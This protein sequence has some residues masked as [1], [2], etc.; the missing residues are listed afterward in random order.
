MGERG[1]GGTEN[2]GTGEPARQ[3]LSFFLEKKKEA[4]KNRLGVINK[5]FWGAF[6]VLLAWKRGNGQCH[7]LAQRELDGNECLTTAVNSEQ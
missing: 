6:W 5:S 1:D 4:K 3:C 7:F 2:E